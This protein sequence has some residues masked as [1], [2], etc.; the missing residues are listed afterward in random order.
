MVMLLMAVKKG[1]KGR[2][3]GHSLSSFR[4]SVSQLLLESIIVSTYEIG[5]RVDDIRDPAS[6][7]SLK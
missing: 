2:K 4:F 3:K 6:L 7:D 5:S 1:K